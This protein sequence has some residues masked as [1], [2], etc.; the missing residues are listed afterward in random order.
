MNSSASLLF[1]PVGQKQTVMRVYIGR[2]GRLVA[3]ESPKMNSVD[4]PNSDYIVH[5]HR[6]GESLFQNGST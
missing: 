1:W 2:A 3:D 5:P 6:K 4:E